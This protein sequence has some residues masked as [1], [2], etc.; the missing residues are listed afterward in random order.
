VTA[1]ADLTQRFVDD[2]SLFSRVAL[3]LRRKFSARLAARPGHT[4]GGFIDDAPRAASQ[5]APAHPVSPTPQ[6][7]TLARYYANLELPYGAALDAVREARRRL[8]KRYH[9]D[10]HSTDPG[11]RR[12]ATQVTQGLNHAHDELISHLSHNEQ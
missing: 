10:L 9:P 1:V 8:I 2:M 5:G 4:G 12:T 3:L 6:D 11:R 7:P